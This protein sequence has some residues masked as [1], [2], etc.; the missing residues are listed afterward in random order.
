MWSKDVDDSEF[1]GGEL[2]Y[3]KQ[4]YIKELAVGWKPRCKTYEECKK[5]KTMD[6]AK[7]SVEKILEIA[8]KHGYACVVGFRQ[9]GEDSDFD[10][11]KSELRDTWG[12]CTGLQKDVDKLMCDC[13]QPVW[14]RYKDGV[15]NEE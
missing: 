10:P 2:V 6:S 8:K 12:G 1:I 9:V 14:D 11:N 13:L 7:K 4:A 15:K 3:P 5:G